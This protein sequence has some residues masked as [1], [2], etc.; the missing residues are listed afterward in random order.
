MDQESQ[1]SSRSNSFLKETEHNSDIGSD[2]RRDIDCK[3]EHSRVNS[4]YVFPR[5][6]VFQERRNPPKFT[7]FSIKTVKI[8]RIKKSVT[9][10]SNISLVPLQKIP[11]IKPVLVH[12]VNSSLV[13][14]KHQRFLSEQ[15]HSLN[16]FAYSPYIQQLT[17]VAKS[18][19]VKRLIISSI[20]DKN[21]GVKY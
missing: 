3:F 5:S 7:N 18:K 17:P 9:F 6:K 19:S 1:L 20:M 14:T 16:K 2:V 10:K 8:K 12:S 21:E 4:F 15:K 11:K 13:K